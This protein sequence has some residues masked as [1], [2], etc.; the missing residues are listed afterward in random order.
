[1]KVGY[2][3]A[4]ADKPEMYEGREMPCQQE[5]ANWVSEI[6]WNTYPDELVFFWSQD[7][8]MLGMRT[9]QSV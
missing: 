1:M 8:D 6:W 7:E 2:W 3:W 9:F 5:E 4:S